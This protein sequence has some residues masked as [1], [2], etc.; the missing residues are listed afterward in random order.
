MPI[1]EYQCKACG[2]HLEEIQGFNDAP[3]TK[4]PQ[5]KKAKLVK[6][7]SAPSFHLK[8]TGWYATDFKNAGKPKATNEKSA[9][10][11]KETSKETTK[12]KT[13]DKKET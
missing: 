5:C 8:G 9:D 10:K 11:P 12:E 6:L 4:C 2:H 1:Y 3:L 13:K 7:V